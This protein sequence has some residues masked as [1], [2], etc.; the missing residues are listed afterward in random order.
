MARTSLASALVALET[1]HPGIGEALA[2]DHKIV[3]DIASKLATYGS[4]SEK[5]IALVFRLAAE[6]KA[7]KATVPAGRAE[8]VAVVTSLKEVESNYGGFYNRCGAYVGGKVTTKMTAKVETASGSYRVYGTVPSALV[9][10]TKVGDTL[11]FT[12]TFEAS[13]DDPS[14]GFFK[15]PSCAERVEA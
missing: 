11:R 4:L 1:A 9:E 10:T 3:R 14:F 7:P 12:A 5:Q 6:S 8:V 15:R 13:K 2:A